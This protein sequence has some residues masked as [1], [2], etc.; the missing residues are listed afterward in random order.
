VDR[1]LDQTASFAKLD[2]TTQRAIRDSLANVAEYLSFGEGHPQG[3]LAG[4]LA[5]PDLQSRLSRSPSGANPNAPLAG[6]RPGGAPAA[7]TSPSP[8]SGSSV[9]ARAGEVA[10]ATLNAIAFPDFVAS[11]IQGTFQA[12]VDS[13]V[14]QMEGYAELLRHVASTIDQFMQETVSDGMARDYLADRFD[15]LISR[16]TSNGRPQLRVNANAG[17]GE[18]P[19]FFKDLGFESTDGLTEDTIEE[20][21][22]PAARRALAEMRQQ[23]LATMVLMGINR[24][25][26]DEGEIFAKLQFH[27]DASE[28]MALR[29]DQTKTTQGNMARTSGRSPFSANAV[30]VNTT[31]L[32]AQTDLNLR[33]DLTGQVKVRFRSDVFPL[34]RF[35]DTAAIQLINQNARVPEARPNP[36]P[37]PTASPASSTSPTSPPSPPAPAPSSGGAVEARSTT[38]ATQSVVRRVDPWRPRRTRT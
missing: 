30:M 34:E 7:S 38:P 5:P 36:A 12:I 10:R 2:H 20:T 35:A 13:S 24:I 8:G 18:L 6:P 29:F 23:V 26:V 14:K 22:V 16:D 21:A 9:T 4:P 37:A 11:L 17:G 28:T 31:S 27:I 25:V 15:G 1:L 3:V 19:S 33:A 32:N